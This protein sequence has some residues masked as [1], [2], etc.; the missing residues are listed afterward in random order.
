MISEAEMVK[1]AN[2]RTENV[3]SCFCA[4]TL[5]L[6]I[7]AQVKSL[8][9]FRERREKHHVFLVTADFGPPPAATEE[10]PHPKAQAVPGSFVVL[11]YGKK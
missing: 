5:P 11:V 2:T 9:Q 7:R 4:A 3:V 8:V 1:A 6:L 10:N